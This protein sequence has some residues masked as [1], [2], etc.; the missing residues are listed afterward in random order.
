MSAAAMPELQIGDL[1]F[2]R[3]PV[4]FFRKVA[5]TTASWT[6]HV[7]IV[8]GQKDGVW[9]VAESCVPFARQRSFDAFVARSENRRYCIRRLPVPLDADQQQRL[10]QAVARRLGT[11][12]HTGFALHSRRQFCSKFVHEVL[13]EACGIRVGR[14]ETFA[15]LLGRNPD[16]QLGFWRLWFFGRI[17]WRRETITP[18]SELSCPHMTTVFDCA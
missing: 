8:T 13:R 10:Q 3:I 2:I 6:N 9:Q 14:I 7:G 15:Q 5:D 12:Y 16:A 11:L 1:V 4:L 18:A 17:P